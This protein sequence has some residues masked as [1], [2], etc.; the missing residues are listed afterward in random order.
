MMLTRKGRPIWL[1]MPYEP[2]NGVWLQDDRLRHSHHFVKDPWPH[3]E[4]PRAWLTETAQLIVDA[5]GGCYIVQ[6]LRACEQCAPSCWNATGLDCECSCMGAHHGE[7]HPA[8]RWYE[9][10]DTCAVRWGEHRLH[11]KLL[12]RTTG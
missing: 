4:L 3:W 7:G 12:R 11:Y 8:G 6:A 9:V 5:Y 2:N 1:V 10:S